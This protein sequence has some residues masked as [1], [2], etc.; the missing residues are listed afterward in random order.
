[1]SAW[2]KVSE[3]MP[4][5]DQHVLVKTSYGRIEDAYA[6][7]KWGGCY[8]AKETGGGGIAI[9]DVVAWMSIPR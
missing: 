9:P 1:M 6:G 5:H 8:T 7:G 4:K 2:T 3:A